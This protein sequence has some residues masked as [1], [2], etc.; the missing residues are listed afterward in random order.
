MKHLY[1][2]IL[3]VAFLSSARCVSGQDRSRLDSEKYFEV[4]IQ[5]DEKPASIDN[6]QVILRKTSFTIVLYL[7]QPDG[8]LINAS[9]TPESFESA[10]SGKPLKEI[11]GFEDLGMAEDIFNPKAMLIISS[12]APHYWY[13]ENDANHRFNEVKKERGMFICKRIIANLL[14]RDTT[15]QYVSVK[16]IPENELYLVFMKTE[17]TKDFSA[18]IEKQREYIKVIFR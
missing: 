12:R 17:W 7:K 9:L 2:I 16:N 4:G 8:I 11:M 10:R 6:H 5:Q 15:Q 1:F 14:Y 13:Y 3:T 18:Q